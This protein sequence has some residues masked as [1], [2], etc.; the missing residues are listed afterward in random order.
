MSSPSAIDRAEG[1]GHDV[2]DI[3]RCSADSYCRENK[4]PL[5]HLKVIQDVI[6]CR[7]ARLG[8]HMHRCSSC[9]HE[10]PVYNPCGNRHCPGCQSLAKARWLAKRKSELL[11]VKYFHMVFTLPHLL[12][13]LTR[14][15]KRIIY[16]LLFKATSETILEFGSDPKHGLGG[17]VGFMSTLHTWD[18]KLLEHTHLHCIIPGGALSRDESR[19]ISSRDNFLFPVKAL[20]RAFRGRFIGGLKEA[21]TLEKLNLPWFM[22]V[23]DFHSL[24]AKLWKTEWVVYSKRPFAGPG[25]AFDYLARYV[26]RVGISNERIRSFKNGQ[27]TFSWRDR[28]DGNREKTLTVPAHEFIRRFMLHVLP[29]QYM[30]IRYYGFLFNRGRKQNLATCRR[31]LG[32]EPTAVEPEPETA[33]EL[34]LRLAGIDICLCPE[35]K[36]GTMERTR[37]IHREMFTGSWFKR[38]EPPDT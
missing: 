17:K 36:S 28:S 14:Y 24:T 3:F 35:C 8:G 16:D 37:L 25:K 9:G 19:W 1:S 13:P 12:N 11:P 21:F 2:A 15:N 18:Q 34:M 30:R 7:T 33:R 27:V 5:S 4:L 38:K 32:V 23:S 10:H 26:H 20:S 22:T 29:A 6:S 31:L